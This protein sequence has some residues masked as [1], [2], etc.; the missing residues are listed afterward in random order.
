M[1]STHDEQALAAAYVLGALD[2]GERQAFESH[3][4]TCPVCAGEVRSLQRVTDALSR[5]VP[6]RTPRPELRTRVLSTV[7]GKS[8]TREQQISRRN[9]SAVWLPLAAGIILVAALGGYARVLQGRVSNLEARLDVAERRAATAEQATLEARRAADGARTVLAVLAA[10]DLTRVDLAGLK[11]SP[12]AAARAL[13]SRNRGMVFTVSGLPA[14]PAGRVYQVW[15][16]TGPAPVSA[17]LLDL[18]RSGTAT[19]FFQTPPDIA[20]PVAVA[21][22]LEPA[23]GVPAPTG[24][25]YLIGKPGRA[26]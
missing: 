13:W 23:G 21:V 4:R 22:T 24:E 9:Y 16:V 11:P 8:E 14:A 1:T 25:M 12:S 20:A 5:S 2:A 3:L 26:L 19:A 15:V 10:P 17:G 6:E 18:D 7:T